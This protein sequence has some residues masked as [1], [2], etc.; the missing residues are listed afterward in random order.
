MN[1]DKYSSIIDLPYR[2]SSRHNPMSLEA[3]SA[4]FAPFA[5]LT[6]YEEG[7]IEA[8]RRTERKISLD[9]SYVDALNAKLQWLEDNI[10]IKPEVTITYFVPDKRKSGGSY[11]TIKG[12]VRR[13]DIV[14]Q[15]VILTDKTEI[16]LSEILSITGDI[17][18]ELD[19]E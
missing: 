7:I 6:G 16:Y 10:S 17:F 15:V 8:A 14:N 11:T 13:I 1:N 12:C 5:A 18:N 19:S 9:E 3:R 2:K 4:Q